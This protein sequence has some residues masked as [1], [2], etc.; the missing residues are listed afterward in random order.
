MTNDDLRQLVRIRHELRRLLPTRPG[1]EDR[2]AARQLLARMRDLA[3]PNAAE[4]ARI[5]PE[6][7]RWQ[8]RFQLGT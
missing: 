7:T 6:L 1:G 4:N 3:A 5:E 2:D 8:A